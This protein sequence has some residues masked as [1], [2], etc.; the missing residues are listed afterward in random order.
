MK[1][2]PT[3]TPKTVSE[4]CQVLLHAQLGEADIGAI[5]V[6]DDVEEE[7]ERQYSPRDFPPRTVGDP[8]DLVGGRGK[9]RHRRDYEGG[10]AA[11]HTRRGLAR[12]KGL[13]RRL[14]SQ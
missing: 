9:V 7:E 12:G 3:P 6:R 11:Y 2:S 13:W 1:N 14:P 8:G 5:E 4:K 10:R